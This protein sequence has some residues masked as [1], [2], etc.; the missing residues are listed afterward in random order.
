LDDARHTRDARLNLDSDI[1]NGIPVV[2]HAKG[3][4]HHAKGDEEARDAA[5]TAASRT[6]CV[7]LGGAA[8]FAVGGPAGVA[9]GAIAGGAGADGCITAVQSGAKGEYRPAGY[10][11]H[12]ENIRNARGCRKSGAGFDMFAQ[13]YMD[14]QTGN[15]GAKWSQYLV[16]GGPD[17]PGGGGPD[18]PNGTGGDP[19]PGDGG[20]GGG[21]GGP[22]DVDGGG[23]DMGNNNNGPTATCP[24]GGTPDPLPSK[25]PPGG[26]QSPDMPGDTKG[27]QG[28]GIPQSPTFPP[29]RWGQQLPPPS[30][31]NA[32]GA[33]GGRDWE[34]E[35]KF[36]V[37]SGKTATVRLNSQYQIVQFH[38]TIDQSD[39]DAGNRNQRASASTYVRTTGGGRPNDEAG[40]ILACCLGGPMD[41]NQNLIPQ[42]RYANLTQYHICE[43]LIY[44]HLRRY[45]GSASLSIYFHLDHNGRPSIIQYIARFTRH[46]EDDFD[47]FIP[48]NK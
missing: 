29:R 15:R 31:V 27:L 32:C 1:L 12:A 35:D 40:H 17:A 41:I 23:A 24:K 7:M 28:L 21:G 3:A 8:G 45:G 48:N 18:A 14:V 19:S 2:G 4:Y 26:P 16:G 38:V 13:G 22:P 6:T 20:V 5:V 10:V 30:L 42:A 33:G 34:Y 9:V 37:G 44:D 36:P 25:F 47:V 39:L 11:R 43:R 46:S